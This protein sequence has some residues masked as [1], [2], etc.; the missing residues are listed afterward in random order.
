MTRAVTPRPHQVQAAARDPRL[1][2]ARCAN[3][4]DPFWRTQGRCRT[5]DPETFYPLPTEPADMALALCRGCDVQASCLAA[6]L[7]AG[8][9]EGIWGATTPRERRAMLLAWNNNSGPI[10]QP[11]T[12]PA[13]RATVD[14]QPI[15]VEP[16][17]DLCANRHEQRRAEQAAS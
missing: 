10:P 5:V 15:P 3:P 16:V 6:A 8:D 2:R 17:P 7:N 14:R 1:L 12:P 9:C 11:A 13:W 4:D